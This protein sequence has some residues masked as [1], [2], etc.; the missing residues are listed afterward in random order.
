MAIE[1]LAIKIRCNNNIRGLEIQGLKTKVS[2]YADDS[3]FMLSA[4]ARSLQCLIKDLDNFSVFS[5]LKPNYDKCTILR[6]GSLKNTTFTLSCSLH[7]KRADGEVDIL[8]IHITK[9]INKLSTMNFNR[10]LVKI[11]KILQPWRGK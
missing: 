4:Q 7:I 8:G 11:D 1:M 6:I 10:K 2:M 5:G 3:S 9:D